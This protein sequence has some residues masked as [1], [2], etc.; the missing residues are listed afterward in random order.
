MRWKSSRRGWD[1]GAT[2]VEAAIT[3]SIALALVLGIIEFGMALWQWNTMTLAVEEAGRCVMVPSSNA[4]SCNTATASC[5]QTNMKNTL[6][7]Y[8]GLVTS[9]N[10][11]ICASATTPPT[12]TAGSLGNICV[13]ATAPAG[14]N[15][16]TMTLTAIY[17]YNSII[18][19]SKLLAGTLAGPFKATSQ[20]TFP[21]D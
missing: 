6:S 8:V 9:V 18:V 10:N 7:S 4:C 19:P 21:L 5:A 15:P 3:I 16:Q 17:A 11:G 14:A 13:F 2:A 1:E 12:L 20:A